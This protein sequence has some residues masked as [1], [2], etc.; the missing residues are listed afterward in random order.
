MDALTLNSTSKKPLS[1]AHLRAQR[2]NA[3]R[4]TGPRTREGRRRSALN[5]LGAKSSGWRA[6]GGVN[7][8]GRRDFLRVWRDLLALFWFIDP[9]CWREH[10]RL[11]FSFR[12]VAW[13][14]SW[15]LPAIRGGSAGPSLNEPIDSALSRFLFEFHLCNQKSRYWLRKKFGTDGRWNIVKLRES[16]ETRLS[17]FVEAET[18][19]KK[20][21]GASVQPNPSPY[22]SPEIGV[23][24][25]F[26]PP[27]P[28]IFKERTQSRK[29]KTGEELGLEWP[30]FR[31][32]F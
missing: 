7:T 17:S 19:A 15:K 25:L 8:R 21:P 28:G 3:Q 32:R 1:P 29:P 18:I 20:A 11:E 26:T 16:I 6:L 31:V 5:R 12:E 10:P 4:S 24:P 2:A 30:R 23:S 13:V 9:E 27:S 14:W 22:P